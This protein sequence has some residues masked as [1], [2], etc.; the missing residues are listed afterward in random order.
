MNAIIFDTETLNLNKP[1][2]YNV[3]Y[4]I[5][6]LANGKVL[7][8]RDFVIKQIY[9]NKILFNS[10]YYAD[11]RPLYTS[12]MKGRTAKKVYWG[13]MCR[14]MCNDIKQHQVADGFA[15]NASFDI[16]VFDYNHNYFKNKRKPLNLLNVHDIMDYIEPIISLKEYDDFTRANG[17]ITESGRT[18][19]TAETLFAYLTNNKDYAEEHTA[20]EDSKIETDILLTALASIWE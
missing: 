4:Q 10:A 14:Q 15:Y 18:K 16:K 8:K 19:R 11:K 13:E 2:C 9:D 20:L 7:C 12:K 6:D 1:N 5:V 3:G 17:N